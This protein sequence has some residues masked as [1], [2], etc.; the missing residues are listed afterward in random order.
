MQ[1]I[2][3]SVKVGL[4]GITIDNT[5]FDD[6]LIMDI[7]MAFST[8]KQLGVGDTFEIA[9]A[10]AVWSDFITDASIQEMVKTYVI[11]KV[12]MS[13]DPPLGSTAMEALRNSI[14]ELEWRLNVYV[15]PAPVVEEIVIVEENQNG[16]LQGE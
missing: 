15:D 1:S 9:D 13:F 6:I 2:L 3:N 16:I 12:K 5:D 7:N 10:S 14:A 4:G 11:K 8:L